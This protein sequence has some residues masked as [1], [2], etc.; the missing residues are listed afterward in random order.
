MEITFRTVKKLL[1]EARG[2]FENKVTY[3]NVENRKVPNELEDLVGEFIDRKS[4]VST[5]VL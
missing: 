5:G 2:S 4:K 3:G 1:L